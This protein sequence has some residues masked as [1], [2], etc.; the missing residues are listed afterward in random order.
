MENL[1]LTKE[2]KQILK[3][4]E[5]LTS[6]WIKLLRS[7]Y[8][9]Q[10]NYRM[11]DPDV[12][13]SCCCLMVAEIANGRKWEDHY[14]HRNNFVVALTPMGLR[15]GLEWTHTLLANTKAGTPFY[16]P[17]DW[18]DILRMNFDQI[19]DLLEHGKVEVD[20]EKLW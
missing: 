16:K 3:E 12:P 8:Y 4:K 1:Q 7:G 6:E 19:A 2:S 5:P 9:T 17:E 11:A 20:A 13:N 14:N 15:D 18:N 10:E